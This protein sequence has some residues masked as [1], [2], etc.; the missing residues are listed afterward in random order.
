MVSFNQLNIVIGI[1]ARFFSNYLIL[2]LGQSDSAWA[3]SLQFGEWSWRW[4]LG[5]ET[6]PAIL[7]FFALM[8]V[9]E[10]PRWLAMRGREDEALQILE[11]VSGP[12]QARAI[13]ARCTTA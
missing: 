5:V 6:L 12:E 7:Y 4:M 8:I 3:E 13:Y 9:P 11:K 10:S 1:S 2:T